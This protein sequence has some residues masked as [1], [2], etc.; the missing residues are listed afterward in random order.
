MAI[1]GEK[2][3]TEKGS[4]EEGKGRRVGGG[5]RRRLVERINNG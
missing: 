2:M 5:D 3:E 1:L 4:R